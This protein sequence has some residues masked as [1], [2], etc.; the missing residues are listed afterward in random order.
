MGRNGLQVSKGRLLIT[1]MNKG[2]YMLLSTLV[3]CSTGYRNDGDDYAKDHEV[4]FLQ[5]GNY[6]WG[7]RS[8]FLPLLK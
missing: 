4:V 6:Y 3:S 5:G 8:N 1:K 2:G 7:G